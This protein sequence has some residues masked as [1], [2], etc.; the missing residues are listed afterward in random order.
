MDCNDGRSIKSFH[1]NHS[2]LSINVDKDTSNAWS[3]NVMDCRFGRSNQIII[4]IIW[5]PRITNEQ[6]VKLYDSLSIVPIW[7]DCNC[8]RFF[9][10]NSPPKSLKLFSPIWMDSSDSQF[11]MWND[12]DWSFPQPFFWVNELIPILIV[13]NRFN[14]SILNV[15]TEPKQ[16]FPIS[17][18]SNELRLCTQYSVL[19][20][21][22]KLPNVMDCRFGR[23]NHYNI[24]YHMN[25]SNHKWTTSK[26]VWFSFNCTDLNGL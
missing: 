10:S 20:P 14:P 7:M 18:D 2:I 9:N 23:S 25:T 15:F 13:F 17:I 8:G 3:P 16:L 5:I 6:P 22:T 24:Q 19:F 26:I 4:N 12:F 11:N 21:N 1:S